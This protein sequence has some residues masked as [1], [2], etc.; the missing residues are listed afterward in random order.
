MSDVHPVRRLQA[1]FRLRHLVCLLAG[2]TGLFLPQMRVSAQ[3]I[4]V[5]R[6]NS[7][8]PE[9]RS[10]EFS[11]K[12]SFQ[13]AQLMQF[14]ATDASE[15]LRQLPGVQIVQQ[16]SKASEVRLRGM[17]NGYVQ[18]LVDGQL[19]PRGFSV[20]SIPASQIE[21][22]EIERTPGAGQSQQAAAGS[23]NL[24]L[25][26]RFRAG[27][28]ETELT[29]AFRQGRWSPVFAVRQSGQ[30]GDVSG[31][32]N[33]QTEQ[34][35]DD[36]LLQADRRSNDVQHTMQQT[37]TETSQQRKTALSSQQRLQWRMPSGD[38][39]G[40][41]SWLQWLRPQQDKQRQENVLAGDAVPFPF[42][43]SQFAA[44]NRSWRQEVQWDKA[45]A[46]WGKLNMIAGWNQV[47]RRTRYDFSGSDQQ[48]RLTEKR[49]VTGSVHDNEFR[50]AL[51][52]QQLNADEQGWKGG[53]SWQPASRTE[54]RDETDQPL[55]GGMP[56]SDQRRFI[57][58]SSRS[59]LWLERNW[60]QQTGWHQQ[61][62]L[63]MEYWQNRLRS[64]GLADVTQ[65]RWLISPVWQQVW[66]ASEGREWRLG[67][68]QSWKLPTA[69]QLIP[70]RYRVDDHN[71][72]FNPDQSG[73][74]AL[75]PEAITG[76]EFSHQRTLDKD[77]ALEL[78]MFARRMRD[79]IGYDLTQTNGIWNSSP[80]N[81]GN[82]RW[83]GVEAEL[84]RDGKLG[85]LRYQIRWHAYANWSRL[86]AN[87]VQSRLPEQIP[88]GSQWQ[89]DL[90]Q[91]AWKTGLSLQWQ[92]KET[93]NETGV[94]QA[95]NHHPLQLDWYLHWQHGN[96]QFKLSV[97]DMLARSQNSDDRFQWQNQTLEENM[98]VSKARTLK[99]VWQSKL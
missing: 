31:L 97:T 59:T 93:Y 18:I 48:N 26:P 64:N 1:V 16:G 20:D 35:T 56:E 98:R 27:Q 84:K 7:G 67:I 57:A 91:G 9:G 63:R 54:T 12:Q 68:S 24:I 13:R 37:L 92:G 19:M 47:L 62:G 55:N 87:G 96:Q 86:H 34:Q 90:Q 8:A 14:G 21:R 99:L 40:W 88:Y 78:G 15:L 75:K 80:V 10:D 74:P 53:I 89:L 39:L 3:E 33:L 41:Q 6:V 11:N 76:I 72:P 32:W 95:E 82:A 60:F 42:N 43:Q 5:V 73:N 58:D 79:R 52:W 94:L 17:G 70:R 28:T 85:E 2:G 83:L 29:Q 71:S 50:L 69:F 77:T 66:K 25:K 51:N 23:I 44:L 4:Q 38:Q 46:D 30:H 49:L 36:G 81:Q 61:A 45:E 22:I 65:G